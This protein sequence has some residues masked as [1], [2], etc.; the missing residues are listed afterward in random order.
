MFE[1]HPQLQGDTSIICELAIC[2]A[3]LMN[4]KRYPW[5]ILVPRLPDLRDLHDVPEAQSNAVTEE[6]RL[7]SKALVTCF[8]PHKLNVAALGNMVPQLHIHIIARNQDDPAWP[9]PVWGVG[10]AEPY[11]SEVQQARIEMLRQQL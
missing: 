5:V 8:R 3:L 11:T 10:D 7:V 4:D 1:L 9:G 6:I 2:S